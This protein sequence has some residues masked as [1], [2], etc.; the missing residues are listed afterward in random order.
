M[1]P[2][3]DDAPRSITPYVNYF[4]IGLNVA[5]FLFEYS[6]STRELRILVMQFGFVPANVSRW[7]AGLIPMDVA[8][9]PVLT[10]MFLHASWLHLI[11]NMWALA[12]FGD[13]LEDRL[14]H[15]GY[16]LFYLL[17]GLGA[18]VVHFVFNSTAQIPSVGASG[19]I[20]GVMGAYFVLFPSARVL[21]WVFT[22]ALIRLPA[23]LVLGYWF[24]AQLLSGAAT[25]I[26]ESRETGGG[27]AV[28]AHVG[29]FITGLILIKLFPLR[30]TY[31]S[32][33]PN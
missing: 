21:T 32:Y 6:L 23:W 11:F 20:A 30:P 4:L 18:D 2:I 33:E 29:G 7:I 31:Y 27:V 5:V 1:I 3:K 26:T 16:L 13:N 19:A 12:I 15:F 8:L 24:L 17:S 22:F 28:W 9:V 10:S 14:G 25:A